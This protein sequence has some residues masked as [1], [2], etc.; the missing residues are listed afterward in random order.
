GRPADGHT[1]RR[2][3]VRGTSPRRRLVGLVLWWSENA[4]QE[5][6]AQQVVDAEEAAVVVAANQ[7][8]EQPAAV[9]AAVALVDVVAGV[10]AVGGGDDLQLLANVL[11]AGLADRLGDRHVALAEDA[12]E[13]QPQGVHRHRHR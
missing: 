4:V 3:E 6:A 1:G 7:A 12:V 10:L 11:A 5:A 8:A 9:T 2:G 13:G